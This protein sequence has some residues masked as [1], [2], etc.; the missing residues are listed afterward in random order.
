MNNTCALTDMPLPM[1]IAFVDCPSESQPALATQVF[2]T[3]LIG[4]GMTALLAICTRNCYRVLRG[5]HVMTV[6]M[7]VY[8]P[9]LKGRP[10]EE[11]DTCEKISMC[12]IMLFC[13]AY[14]AVTA[15]ATGY[16][17]IHILS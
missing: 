6:P 3:A 12:A 4:G 14:T 17:L 15:T 7:C 11:R 1:N 13:A 2:F 16:L 8:G 5:T 10:I 9:M